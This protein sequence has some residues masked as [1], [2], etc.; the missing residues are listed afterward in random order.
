MLTEG[1]GRKPPV[2]I[3]F[4]VS[5]G[6]LIVLRYAAEKRAEHRGYSRKKTTWE[7]GLQGSIELDGL[8]RITQAVRP[9]FAGLMGEYFTAKVLGGSLDLAL[10]ASGDGGVDMVCGGL[11]IQV[12]TCQEANGA[13][14]VKVRRANGTAIH[15]TARVF[16][17]CAIDCW[18][19]IN[20]RGWIWTA[21]M[22][23]FPEEPAR[24]G[25]H[26]NFAIP[27]ASLSPMSALV[28]E[29]EARKAAR[30]GNH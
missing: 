9:I 5:L 11:P 16:V 19:A 2:P 3:K 27:D 1:V 18:R 8:G 13:N 26:F 24:K 30:N 4:R 20:V 25:D 10:T 7:Q 23:G 15:Q 14:L 21:E 22:L 17:F 6:E 12:K 28:D 29:I